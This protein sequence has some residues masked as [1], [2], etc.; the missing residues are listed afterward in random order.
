MSIED[1]LKTPA[2]ILKDFMYIQERYGKARKAARRKRKLEEKPS[3]NLNPPAKRK[4]RF[5]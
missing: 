5:R 4:R 1:I 3:A 2:T